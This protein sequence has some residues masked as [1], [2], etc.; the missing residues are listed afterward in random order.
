M[1][2]VILFRS[3]RDTRDEMAVASNYFE[4]VKSRTS[5]AI[6]GSL[7][8]PRYSALPFMD[9]LENDLKLC[10]ARLVNSYRQHKW[11]ADFTY[12][13]VLKD[14]T[15]RSWT[16]EEYTRCD[17]DGAV[18]VKGATNSRKFYF[19]KTMLAQ[20]RERALEIANVLRDD[21][22]IGQQKI[23]FREYVPL[24][25]FEIGLFGLPFSNEFRLFFHKRQLLCSGYYWQNMAE[26]ESIAQAELTAEG[27]ELAHEV[28]AIASEYVNFFVVDV[29]ERKSGGWV[30]VE[31]ND[32]C[33]AGLS[34]CDPHELYANLSR[35]V[36]AP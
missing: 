17:F 18:V 3:D 32:G 7:V 25:S 28:A 35:S 33:Q 14:F 4:V 6:P 11:I 23:I 12:Y 24:R 29:A 10:G 15:F 20:T 34:A 8:I 27:L 1:T 2:P 5:S 13:Q 16:E 21:S 19:N 31:L 9:E 36:V 30:L 22:M 26:P